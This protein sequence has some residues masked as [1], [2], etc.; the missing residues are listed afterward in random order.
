[1]PFD[2]F[3][4]KTPQEVLKVSQEGLG[5]AVVKR[6]VVCALGGVAGFGIPIR[7]VSDGNQQGFLVLG[8]YLLNLL[9]SLLRS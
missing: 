6:A 7:L 1:M 8:P 9:M 2:I 4:K 5:S 3:L